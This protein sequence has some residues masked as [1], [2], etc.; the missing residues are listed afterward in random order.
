MKLTCGALIVVAALGGCSKSQ[1]ALGE[2]GDE[3]EVDRVIEITTSDDLRFD[4]SEISVEA[5][6]TIEFHV[7]NEASSQHEFVLGPTHDHD[8]GMQHGDASATGAIDPG[9]SA[10]V[11]WYFPEAGETSFACHIANHDKS[12]MTGTVTVS[13]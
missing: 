2:A 9:D 1:P 12:G 7:T 10:S 8:E 11:V 6:E 13:E 3:A 5:G 4:P